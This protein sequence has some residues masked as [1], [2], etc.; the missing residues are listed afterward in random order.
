VATGEG[1][2]ANDPGG[3]GGVAATI[4]PAGPGIGY[5]IKITCP[6]GQT[7]GIDL[8]ESKTGYKCYRAHFETGPCASCP[9]KERCLAREAKSGR[10]RTLSFDER[11]V[12]I[13]RRRRRI[14][15]D[16][17]AGVNLRV[18]IESTIGSLKQAFNYDQ[19]PVRGLFRVGM[20]LVGGAAMAN[21]RRI[22]RY[23]SRKGAIEG[24]CGAAKGTGDGNKGESWPLLASAGRMLRHLIGLRTP[25]YTF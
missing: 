14:V 1:S 15:Q 6:H 21:V 10:F 17:E 19:L 11:D 4:P 22:H 13:A 2:K 18:A 23:M 3:A 5:P 16:R 25:S 12:E 9:F 24:P 20:V 8:V 7:V